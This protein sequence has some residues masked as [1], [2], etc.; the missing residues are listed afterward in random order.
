MH[1]FLSSEAPSC[2]DSFDVGLDYLQTE[3]AK[4]YIAD[5]LWK[6]VMDL[7]GIAEENSIELNDLI[8]VDDQATIK[9]DIEEFVTALSAVTSLLKES[10]TQLCGSQW[11]WILN[12]FDIFLPNNKIAQFCTQYAYENSISKLKYILSGRLTWCTR[13]KSDFQEN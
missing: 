1:Y 3:D 2:S 5:H 10:K 4:D 6:L 11:I 12:I 9:D 13:F 7:V 8:N